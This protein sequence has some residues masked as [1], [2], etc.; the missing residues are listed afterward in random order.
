[1]R[2]HLIELVAFSTYAE[3]RAERARSY[4]GLLWWVLEP[5]MQMGAYWLEY[6]VIYKHGGH[7]YLPIHLIYN[8]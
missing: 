8:N 7:D 2:Q 6:G 3:L 4:L 1:M 5:A